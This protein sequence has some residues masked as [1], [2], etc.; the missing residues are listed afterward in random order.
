[1]SRRFLTLVALAL[2]C[3]APA[4]AATVSDTTSAVAAKRGI[5]KSSSNEVRFSADATKPW[6]AEWADVSCA[7]D[8]RV[9]RVKNPV[10]MGRRAYRVR[11]QE[12]DESYGERVERKLVEFTEEFKHRYGTELS[13]EAWQ[14]FLSEN[15]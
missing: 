12:G 9:T 7:S 3:A 5:P 1:M 10:A 8:A 11:L 13:E 2:L 6:P 14:R 15:S 4:S